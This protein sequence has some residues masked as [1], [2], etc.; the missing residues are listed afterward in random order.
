MQVFAAS[1]KDIKKAL[2]LKAKLIID[3]VKKALFIYLKDYAELFLLKEGVKL[4]PY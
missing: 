2:Y 3:K 1:L 4:L